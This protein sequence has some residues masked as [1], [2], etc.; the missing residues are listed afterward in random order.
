[1]C[2]CVCVSVCVCERVCVFVHAR[3][4]ECV[5]A[6]NFNDFKRI[7][8][9]VMDRVLSLLSA[10]SRLVFCGELRDLPV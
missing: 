9:Y 10:L 1:M 4:R 2:L 5:C 6:Y 3:V 7:D 8:I